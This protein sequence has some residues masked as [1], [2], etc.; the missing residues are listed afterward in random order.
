MK[1]VLRSLRTVQWVVRNEETDYLPIVHVVIYVY[2]IQRGML[3]VMFNITR[4]YEHICIRYM[5]V[6]L[7]NAW[8]H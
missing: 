8:A 2:H 3:L 5:S 7:W 6:N 4:Q 1:D